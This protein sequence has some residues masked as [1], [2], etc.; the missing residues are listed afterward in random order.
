MNDDMIE[1]YRDGRQKDAVPPGPNRTRS[2]VHG[3]LN[4]RD[5]RLQKPRASAENIRKDA[6]RAELGDAED[7]AS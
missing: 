3:W 2:Y 7:F 6:T 4:G 5:D 1:G